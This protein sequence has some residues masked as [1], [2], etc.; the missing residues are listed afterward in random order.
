MWIVESM[1]VA[2]CGEDE[3][4]EFSVIQGERLTLRHKTA[5]YLRVS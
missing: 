5:A 3:S 1:S 2:D 4:Y